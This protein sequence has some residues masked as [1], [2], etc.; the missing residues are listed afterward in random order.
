MSDVRAVDVPEIRAE[1]IDY[2][3]GLGIE[4]FRILKDMGLMP[5][6][7]SAK[8]LAAAEAKRLADCERWSL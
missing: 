2:M 5:V 6:G 3:G 1:L 7:G 8:E 4:V